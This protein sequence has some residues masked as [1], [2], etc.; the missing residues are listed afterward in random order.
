M[1]YN[2]SSVFDVTLETRITQR[3]ALYHTVKEA[4]ERERYLVVRDL[5]GLRRGAYSNT[6][7]RI[8]NRFDRV[9]RWCAI[10]RQQA[11]VFMPMSGQGFYTKQVKQNFHPEFKNSQTLI[12]IAALRC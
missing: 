5:R 6:G 4:L 8:A 3:L 2:L 1:L 9:A 12:P 10:G 11:D 7:Q